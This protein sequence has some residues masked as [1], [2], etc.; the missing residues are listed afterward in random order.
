MKARQICA[1]AAMAAVCGA[2]PAWATDWFVNDDFQAGLDVYCT[3]AGND[4]ND[5]RSPATPKRSIEAI[6]TSEDFQPGDTLYIDTGTYELGSTYEIF[7][8]SGTEDARITVQGSPKGTW[9]RRNGNPIVRVMGAYMDFRDLRIAGSSSYNALMLTRCHHST[10]SR[11]HVLANSARGITLEVGSATN[12]FD[13]GIVAG[14]STLGIYQYYATAVANDFIS[15]TLFGKGT[16]FSLMANGISQLA[17]SIIAVE[18]TVFSSGKPSNSVTHNLFFCNNINPS[19]GY[20]TI[21]DAQIAE[22]LLFQGNSSGT[23][24]F[25]DAGGMDFHL[26]SPNGYWKTE[27]TNVNGALYVTGGSWVTNDEMGLSP[28]IDFGV[29]NEYA[30]WT[31][32]P[33]PNGGR[34]NAG[35][36]GGT[37]EA[38]KGHSEGE[39]WLYAASYNDGGNLVGNGVFEWRAGGFAAG[40]K[41]RLQYTHDGQTWSNIATVAASAERR[42]WTVSAGAEGAWTKWRVRTTN[43]TGWIAA[44]NAGVF[45]VRASAETKFTYYVNDESTTDDE[46]CSVGGNDANTGVSSNM[47]KRSLQAVLDTFVLLG[48]DEVRM[49]TGSYGDNETTVW[50]ALDSGTEG[51]PIV[52]RGSP[53]GTELNPGNTSRTVLEMAGQWV[54]VKDLTLRGGQYG[55]HVNG[56]ATGNR[57]ENIRATENKRG[58][59]T[60]GSDVQ[61]FDRLAAC[62]NSECGVYMA[63]GKAS[64]N[65]SVVWNNPAAFRPVTGGLTLSNSIAGGS[66][67]ATLFNNGSVGASGDYNVFQATKWVASGTYDNF[68]MY[69]TAVGGWEHCLSTDP[70]FVDAANGDFHLMPGSPAVD[71]GDPDSG[72]GDEPMP[73]G[74]RLNI[75]LYGG[76]REATTSREGGWVEILS[77]RDGGT[78]DAQA[79]ATIR[80][81]AGGLGEGAKASVWLSRDGGTH[82]E[83]LTPEGGVDA[84]TGSWWY[85]KEDVGNTSSQDARLKVTLDGGSESVT[86]KPMAYR[87]G[88]Q[89][90]YVNDGSTEGDVYCGGTGQDAAG[91]GL[92][93]A[94]PAAT[95]T[96]LLANNSLAAGDVVYIDTGTYVEPGALTFDRT[97]AG[98]PEKAIKFIGSTNRVAGGSVLGNRSRV[99]SAGLMVQ[100]SSNLVFR[101]LVFTNHMAAVVVSNA[102]NIVFEKVEVR[103]GR[104][105]GFSVSGGSEDIRLD[106]CVATGCGVGLSMEGGEGV[107]VDQSVFWNNVTGITA[108]AG[109]AGSVS[110]SVLGTEVAEGVL[111]QLAVGH[112][113]TADYNGLY[114][115]GDARVGNVGT[116][117]YDNARAW[118]TETGLDTHSVPGNPLLADPG[119]FD[120]HL[121]TTRTLGRTLPDG[122]KTTDLEDSP[123]LDAGDPGKAPGWQ[124]SGR[125]NIGLYGGLAEA[126]RSRSG[127]WLRAVTFADGGSAG[128]EVVPL[129]WVA[130]AGLTGTTVKVSVSLDGGKTWP[131]TVATGVAAEAGEA[132]WHSGNAGDTPAAMWKVESESKAGVASDNGRFFSVR[133]EPLEIYVATGDTNE[134]SYVTGPGKA[135]NWEAT[136]AAPLNSLLEALKRYDLDGGDTVFVDKGVF[137]EEEALPF[138]VKNTG[139]EGN[140]VRIVGATG[141]PMKDTVLA[142][143]A[144]LTGSRVVELNHAGGVRF[145]SLLISNGWHGVW[146]ANSRGVEFDRVGL[147]NCV[148]N[149]MY[150]G[151]GATVTFSHGAVRD[152]MV[153]GVTANTGAVVRVENSYA[154]TDGGSMFRLWGGTMGVTNN[155]L[156]ATKLGGK[157]YDIASG[158]SVLRADY[159]NIHAEEGAVVA[160]GDATTEARFLY[161]WQ[162]ATRGTDGNSSGYDPLMNDEENGDYHLKSAAGR[163]DPKTQAYVTTDQETSTLIDLGNPGTAWGEEPEPNGGRVNVGVHGGTGEA[164]KSLAGGRIVPLTMSDGGVIRG[165]VTLHWAFTGLP[166][167]AFVNVLFSGDGWAT[168]NLI[169]EHVYLSDEKVQ[170]NTTNVLSTGMGSWR[171]EL[172]GDASV[173]GQT[174]T[175][176][177]VK[178]E[179]L[180][181]YVNDSSTNGDVYC[182]AKGLPGN[183]GISRETPMDSLDRVFGRYKLEPGDKVYVDTGVYRK[184]GSVVLAPSFGTDTNADWLVIQGSTNR[185]AGGTV[186]ENE[187]TGAVLELRGAT[188]TRITD[189]VLKNGTSGMYLNG[190]STNELQRV[191]SD[192]ARNNGFDLGESSTGNRFYECAAM[193]FGRTGLVARAGSLKTDIPT[194]NVWDHGIFLTRAHGT[195]VSPAATALCVAVTSGRLTVS[196]SVFAM[197]G[198]LDTGVGARDGVYVGDYN[199]FYS[200]RRGVVLGTWSV[201]PAP[202][203]GVQQ[204]RAS[205]VDAWRRLSGQDGHSVYGPPLFGDAEAYD[206]HP[207]SMG[208]RWDTGAG[209]WIKDDEVSVL[210]GNG[211]G[212]ENIGWYGS[213]EEASLQ[214]TNE[215]LELLSFRDGGMA[216]GTTELLWKPMGNLRGN[217]TV[218]AILNGTITNLGTVA[219]A[220]GRYVWDTT[221]VGS[222]G[223]ARWRLV[224]QGVAGGD[225]GADFAVRNGPITYYINDA[226]T[227]G[228]EWLGGAG[229][230]GNTGLSAESPMATLPELLARYDLEA[231]DEVWVNAG[232]YQWGNRTSIGWEDSGTAEKP[233]LIKGA[234]HGK[235]RIAGTVLGLAQVRGVKLEDLWLAN[236]NVTGGVDIDRSEDIQLHAVDVAGSRGHALAVQLSSNVWADHCL[237]A[238]AVSN[239][240]NSVGTWG[241]GLDYC[242]VCSN[243]M[244]QIS[245]QWRE[246]GM[247]NTNL[248]ASW[249]GVS[250][251]ILVA[252]GTRIPIY[253]ARGTIWADGNNLFTMDGGL[254]AL[255]HEGAIATE[256]GSVNAWYNASGQDAQSLSYNPEFVDGRYNDFHLK[257]QTGHWSAGGWTGDDTTSVLVDAGSAGASVGDEP[258]PNG[259]RVN[260][261]RYGGTDEASKTAAGGGLVLVSLHDGG[262]ASGTAFP[263][264]WQARGET[265]NATLT[266]QYWDGRTTNILATGVQAGQE[267]WEWNTT[268]LEPSVQGRLTLVASDGQMV[269][270]DVPFA[271][272][273]EGD[274]FEFYVNDGSLEGDEYC[275]AAGSPANDGLTKKTPMADLNALLAKYDLESGDTVYVDTG[276]YLSGVQPW[277]ITQED[278]AGEEGKAPVVIQGATNRL[279]NGTVLDR[280][281]NVTGV[282]AEYTVGLEIR[283]IA[284]SNAST[285]A[286]SL[287]NTYDTLV[288]WCTARDEGRGVA[289][290]GG[291]GARVEHCVFLDVDTGITASGSHTGSDATVVLKGPEIRHNVIRARGDA[292]LSLNGTWTAAAK[293]NVLIPASSGT[294]VYDVGIRTPFASDYNAI[295][296]AE[297]GRV[298][299][300][301]QAPDESPVPIVCETVG[302]WVNLTGNDAH[303]YDANPEFADYEGDD[304]HLRSRGG[305]WTG[306]E[307]AADSTTSPLVDAGDP[308][309]RVADEPWENGGRVNVGLYG[310]TPE[311]SK[312][313]GS[314]RYTLLT[315]NSGGVAQGRVSLAWNALGSATGNTVRIEVSLDGGTSW[316]VTVGSGVQAVAG[317]VLWN[318]A[319]AGASALAKWRVVDEGEMVETAESEECFTLHNGGIAYYVNDG[320]WSDG[321]YCTAAGDDGNNGLSPDKPKRSVEA[322]LDTYNLEAGDVVYVDGGTYMKESALTIGDL[323][324]GE[325]GSD[326]ARVRIL[327]QESETAEKTV[328]VVLNPE[329]DGVALDGAYGVELTHLE[330]VGASNAVRARNS[331]YVDGEWLILRDGYNGVTASGSSNVWL[332]HSLFWGNRNA[333]GYFS[334]RNGQAGVASSVFWSN[335]YGVYVYQ[336]EV[337]ASNNIFGVFGGDAFA[338]YRRSDQSPNTLRSD[339][340]GFYLEGGHAGGDQSG[341]GNTSR[342]SLYSR[343]S[344]WASKTGRDGHSLSQNPL[345]VDPVGGDFHLKSVNGHWGGMGKGWVTDAAS[346]PMI[347]AG[348]PTAT[349]WL[350]EP[351]PNGR[352]LNMGIYGGTA[353]AS[354]TPQSGWLTPLTLV[355][356]GSAA[357]KIE[358]RWQAG[359]AATNDTVTIEFSYDNGLTWTNVIVSGWSALEGAYIWDSEEWGATALGQWRVYSDRDP[360][361]VGGSHEPF[362]LRNAGT[363][364]YYVNDGTTNGDV[365][366]TA[367]GDDKNDGLTPG[368][369]KATVQ[370]ILAAYELEPEDIVWVDAGL[371]EEGDYPIVIDGRDS[372]WSN[373]YVTIQGSTNPVARTVW[374]APMRA[375]SVCALSYAENVRLRNLTLQNAQVGV[376]FDHAINC[377]L[378]DVRVEWNQDKG[379][380]VTRSEG[381]ELKR[382]LV[383]QNGSMTGGPA[384]TFS[385]SGGDLDQCVLWGSRQA[386]TVGTGGAISISNS[387]MDAR[388]EN[389]RVFSFGVA[390]DGLAGVTADYNAYHMR[391]GALLC[392]QKNLSGGNDLYSTI[393]SWSEASGNDR[394]SLEGELGFADTEKAGDFHLLSPQGR[395]T[396]NDWYETTNHWLVGKD[397]TWSPLIDA[398]NPQADVA[399]EPEPNGGVVNIGIYGNT[400]EA[401]KTPIDPPWVR[402]MSYNTGG[403][404]TKSG[405]LYWNYGGQESGRRVTLEYRSGYEM[406]GHPWVTIATNIP[407]EVR[408]YEWDVSEL[409]LTLALKWRV[410]VEG[411]GYSDESDAYVSV[412]TKTYDYYV[413]DGSTVGDVYCERVGQPYAEGVGTNAV[414]PIDSLSSLLANY[415]VGAGDRVFIDTGVYDLGTNSI[416]LTAMNMGT[417]GYPLSIVGSTN[418]AK[419]GS[420]FVF[421]GRTNGFTLQNTRR[422]DMANLRVTGAQHGI[423]LLNVSDIG[424]E[425]LEVAG[426]SGAGIYVA[427]GANVTTRRSLLVDNGGYGFHVASAAEGSRVLENVTVAN[428]GM[429]EIFTTRALVVENSILANDFGHTLMVLSGDAASVTGD[430]NL[431]QWA[432]GGRLATNV[433]KKQNITNVKQWQEQSGGDAYSF[434]ADPLFVDA[435]GGDYH[436]QS[437]AG[438][439]SNGVWT[440]AE[441]TSWGIDSGNTATDYNGEPKPNGERVNLGAYGGGAQASATDTSKKELLA[442]A[443]TDGGVAGQG[444]LLTWASRGGISDGAS[445]RLEYSAGPGQA[446]QVIGTSTAG[447]GNTGYE[448]NSDWSP[449]PLAQ[450]RVVLASDTNVWGQTG[451][452][453]TYRPTPLIY[454]V[455]DDSRVGDVFTSAVG[456]PTNN[457]YQAGSPL[458][459]VSAVLARYQLSSEDELRVDTGDYELRESVEWTGLNAGSAGKN[460]LLRGSTNTGAKTVFYPAAGMTNAALQFA[461]THD[462]EVQDMTF[463]GFDTAVSIPRDNNR[464]CLTGVEAVESGAVAVDVNQV[465]EVYLTRVLARD[466][467]GHGLQFSRSQPVL[468][469]CVVWG[470]A[471]NALEMGEGVVLSMTN[472][473]LSAKGFG[474]YC[475][476]SATTATVRADFNN[477]YLQDAGQAASINGVQYEQ[478]PQWMRA[479]DQDI[480]TLSI[481]PLFADAANGDFHVRSIYGRYDGTQKKWVKDER[482]EGIPD[483]SPMVDAGHTN[484]MWGAEPDPNGSRRNIGLH[485][486]TWQAS[487]SDTNAWVMAVTAMSGGLLDGT[488][489]LAWV[490]GGD[491]DPNELARL[492][493]SP[494][495]GAENTWTLIGEARLSQGMYYWPSDQKNMGG[496]EK[497]TT[498]PEARWRIVVSGQTNVW[499]MTDVPFGLRNKPFRYYVNDGSVEGDEW[500]TAPGDDGNNGFWPDTPKRTLQSLLERV[501]AEAT[502]EIL[503]DTGVH[504]MLDTNRPVEWLA[505]DGGTEG[506]P[507]R[508]VGSPRG[509]VFAVSNNF[510]GSGIFL[511]NAD[512]VSVSNV[513]FRVG[514][515]LTMRIDLNGLGLTLDQVSVS[516]ANLNLN[517]VQASCND[518]TVLGG[519]VEIAGLSNRVQRM[520]SLQGKV[521]LTGTNSLALNSVVWATNAGTTA[522][523]VKAGS[524]ALTNC[525]VVAPRGTAVGVGGSGVDRL[526]MEG[527]ILVAGGDRKNAALA[528]KGGFAGLK[529]DWN[530]FHV[531]GQAWV[532]ATEDS[533][534]ETLA[535]WQRKSGQDAH[536]VAFDPEFVDGEHGDFHLASLAGH[537]DR[538]RNTFRTDGTHSQLIDMGNPARGTGREVIP[539]GDVQN[540]GAYARTAEASLSDTNY[541]LRAKT[542]NDGGVLKGTDVVLR[543]A[544]NRA[545]AWLGRTVRL[546]Y[547]DGNGETHTIASGVSARDGEYTWDTTGYPDTFEGTWRVVCEQDE[548]VSDETDSPFALRNGTAEFYLAETGDDGNDGLSPNSPMQSFQVLLDK[549][550]LEGGDTVHVAEGD[551]T[552]QTNVLV[553]WSRS[554]EE[555]NPV[556]IVG[557]ETNGGVRLGA[558]RPSVDLRASDIQWSGLKITGHGVTNEETGV[559]LTLNGGV[560]LSGMDFVE[561]GTGIRAVR[562]TNTTIR[563]SSFLHAEYGVWLENSGGST[564]RNLTM[565]EI[566]GGKA[567]IKLK[568]S[569]GNVLENNIF[570]PLADGYAYEIGSSVDLLKNA[571][572]DYNLYDFGAEGAGFYAGAATNLRR[573]QL[574]LWG[575]TNDVNEMHDFRSE[576]GPAKLQ[577]PSQGDFHPK[578]EHGRWN[579]KKWVKTDTETSFAV[580]HGNPWIP[581]GAETKPHGSRINIGRYGGTEEASRGSTSTNMSIRSMDEKD[582]EVSSDDPDWPLVWDAHLL[583]TDTTVYVEFQGNGGEWGLL[584]VTNAYAEHFLWT[585][586]QQ[587]Q[588]TAGKWRVRT[589][590]GTLLPPV[591][592]HYP[593]TTTTNE[594]G[595]LGMPFKD[596][597]LMRFKWEGAK[598]GNRYEIRYS[599]DCGKTWEK[600]PTEYNGPEKIHRSD[601]VVQPGETATEYIF[602]DITSFEKPHRWY[603]MLEYEGSSGSEEAEP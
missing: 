276:R 506:Q 130:S 493:Y 178:N 151:A 342:T 278:S 285:T 121:M 415:P 596:H 384:V 603:Q 9:L 579:G 549:Y 22:P 167:N 166:S 388:G 319:E 536:S 451:T 332:R 367:V 68:E 601:F 561:V 589:E 389:G 217:V 26:Q 381:T 457:G 340:N 582:L 48:G 286:F 133:K 583:P 32:E 292:V 368:T 551:Y 254:V 247:N 410:T 143:S 256:R 401:S 104:E 204:K 542:A 98:T 131:V 362:V 456:S 480:H 124:S 520:E 174:E 51:N 210:V 35:A 186:L 309:E 74:N 114:A 512:Y 559:E 421:N 239:G 360:S 3:E 374:Q 180:S 375:E 431:Y 455:N 17:D 471:S 245:M 382:T 490:Y 453:F 272:R 517:G 391:E 414:V 55:L 422:I 590:D 403:N 240:V 327:G 402:A 44:T 468:D 165:E 482:V 76:T 66:G 105:K 307:W 556:R 246:T 571:A 152:C 427:N 380:S 425:G 271:V 484:A 525:T 335:R 369:P 81:N 423:A 125:V 16:A 57:Y 176:F 522:L 226:L 408:E 599:D 518:L 552:S 234:G 444:Q 58:V 351:D 41:V 289:V 236:S 2:A 530:A 546:E 376:A 56:T 73:N 193:N 39:K 500:C 474:N 60:T 120:Y 296:T 255:T 249:A 21:D 489:N 175:L 126:S 315:Y 275:E 118:E 343:V 220:S 475:Y 269:S 108:R 15:M 492:E 472:S 316:P 440:N 91:R 63:S 318:S 547:V 526:S 533:K 162:Q 90:Y 504:W 149:G 137:A 19:S 181:Y 565:A 279:F 459:S 235:T 505:S 4:A 442:M 325:V 230:D 538:S 516:N 354:K 553:I 177:S 127:E 488:F 25:V 13:H 241:L 284:V 396:T 405:L 50:S 513:G 194:T 378:E 487:K 569:H 371:Y 266:I 192:G 231:G 393:L 463:L 49:D 377:R 407:L 534:W 336:G 112:G 564:L 563:N 454:Y 483:V 222:C 225:N 584:A 460:V 54:E 179:P 581:V 270:N 155:V 42:E 237:F 445:V 197:N 96:W 543:W 110:N 572:M 116:V 293:H 69:R 446:W 14:F 160:G 349:G 452:N 101:N 200:G 400:E 215:V 300:Q 122:T 558:G 301:R 320:L 64:L 62:G 544:E 196:N 138:G 20:T 317:E 385:E 324:S 132:E 507:V 417:D 206:F 207:R 8:K 373:R 18:G 310:G 84:A 346:S 94:T 45:G 183:N 253:D 541:W 251:S 602:E 109:A 424:M 11:V 136:A 570:I 566:P 71:A 578:S 36:Y 228:D 392:E 274:R 406:D 111:Y 248:L 29:D 576:M 260:L 321:D 365:F 156:R 232:T 394:H 223:A 562:A 281:G 441:G 144:R 470:N 498:S 102:L 585:V 195:N 462:V 467:L 395:F 288:A 435:V 313:D 448:W 59:V 426:N 495:N 173:Y 311:A 479:S 461:V 503:V 478:V 494:R 88:A 326:A 23:P 103:G 169:A 78:L 53:K 119:T 93:A 199:A 168:T 330:I 588:T 540:L 312:A 65:R 359:G 37:A 591:E 259:G 31:N 273:N 47:P 434:R 214:P 499:D 97:R 89:P 205:R 244:A 291:S 263:I 142:R 40:E 6:G 386:L 139:S 212:G 209:E 113:L 485:G 182:T 344:A 38:S 339:Y 593:F 598:I 545:G 75:G 509:A 106:R 134:T 594:W 397:D 43:S 187:G 560:E 399:R 390:Y 345:F 141:Q 295:W 497:W 290:S 135:D 70:K 548:A 85:V 586:S 129:R 190:S 580:D 358:L 252:A 107:R 303:T 419:G 477:L 184:N 148:S 34:V 258:E 337:G 7:T 24:L 282:S 185:A 501:D 528:W 439:W 532:G 348:G 469:G 153:F 404:I 356:G 188:A 77:F 95:L 28:G 418:F 412:K 531:T 218:Q 416:A 211:A 476:H 510:A 305:R 302:A 568:G 587:Y 481:D 264:T 323:D 79:G 224:S 449:S 52:L 529:S 147:V 306:T 491:L 163:Y 33:M 171:V 398:G 473:V 353:Q 146:A 347:D 128:R 436:L 429:G 30:S 465:K 550:D 61:Q 299:K 409:P 304:F 328:F 297:N 514:S 145:E 92:S 202:T 154:R 450:W 123:L 172:E 370:A 250:N 334:G 99:T 535:Y 140:P 433:T 537:W 208:G 80:W 170:W 527:N 352:K 595:C 117:F 294:Y 573:W 413:N 464:I 164:S 201:Y 428:N 308:A 265:A 150:V 524:A 432:D 554:G 46:W 161:D 577:N 87:D 283:N 298:S 100:V 257:S 287:E 333:G 555:G 82:W 430:Y 189:M 575:G 383:W 366:C 574:S 314:G 557:A 523:V 157:V 10:F 438:C 280:Q 364:S 502:D 158:T 519:N 86:E 83:Q 338:F 115:G 233:V 216:T 466:G 379:I 322:I 521:T 159:N 496:G 1:M 5:G 277:R 243:G 268:G 329:A 203:F 592:S 355:D 267:K 261:G 27:T 219:A 486:G 227:E 72:V 411:T 437:R 357:G 387:V 221:K 515:P 341:Q 597:G 331:Y 12:R 447:A 567:G 350:A 420:V 361:I 242:T 229:S 511:L 213:G 458:D 238:K 262:K 508:M 198:G 600:W 372:G 191:V 443:L 67:T 539:N 363:I